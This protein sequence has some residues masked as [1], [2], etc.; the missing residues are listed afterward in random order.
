MYR[1]LKNLPLQCEKFPEKFE[2]I[3]ENQENICKQSG[4]VSFNSGE[5]FERKME[6]NVDVQI[7]TENSKFPEKFESF[8]ATYF[9][10]FSRWT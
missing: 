6:L 4:K 5:W 10:Q 2:K 1:L 8:Y 3:P 9:L 7:L